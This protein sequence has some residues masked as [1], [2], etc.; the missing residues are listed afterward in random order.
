MEVGLGPSHIVLDEEPVPL[1]K[2]GDKVP[3]FQPIFIVAKWL[4]A[5]RCHLVW[6]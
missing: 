3:N 6:R 4:D 1:A 2:Q 5:S